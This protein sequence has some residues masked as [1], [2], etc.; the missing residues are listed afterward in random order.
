MSI[1]MHVDV[2]ETQE[3]ENHYIEII[4][5]AMRLMKSQREGV[6][7]GKKRCSGPDAWDTPMFTGSGG[8]EE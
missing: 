6:Q 3:L 5:R 1:N 7:T 4:L 8:M 2:K